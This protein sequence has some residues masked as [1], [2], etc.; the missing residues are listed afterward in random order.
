LKGRIADLTE[1][2][3]KLRGIEDET[4]RGSLIIRQASQARERLA[5][6]RNRDLKAGAIRS[7]LSQLA[8]PI[9]Q[10]ALS[11]GEAIESGLARLEAWIKTEEDRLLAL[12]QVRGAA[13]GNLHELDEADS[14]VSSLTRTLT[15][16]Q[17]K[18]VLIEGMLASAEERRGSVGILVEKAKGV[19]I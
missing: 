6:L 14:K 4:T 2:E 11:D 13:R 3:V 5:T 19:I 15:E 12:Q 18:S 17:K 9:G 1:A 10:A 7:S 8:L 16:N